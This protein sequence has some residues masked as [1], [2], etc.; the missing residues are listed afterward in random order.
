MHSSIAPVGEFGEIL[1]H[2]YESRPH[3]SYAAAYEN[4][5]I[6]SLREW[7]IKDVNNAFWHIPNLY[8]YEL[9]KPDILY[10]LLLGMLEYLI[11]WVMGFL[12]CV[13]RTTD[14]DYIW[15]RFPPY[16]GFTRPNKAYRSFSHWKGKE[17]TN[18]LRMIVAV[19]KAALDRTSGVGPITT[20]HKVHIPKAILCVRYLTDLIALAQYRVHTLGSIKAMQDYLSHV[21]N[22]KDV[23]L[24]LRATKAAKNAIREPSKDMRSE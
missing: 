10:T 9:V 23:F 2:A 19:C 6:A 4:K 24:R 13:R 8:P 20:Q 12:T 15:S 17:I 5:N 11:K 16:P 1:N 21:P 18:L 3:P 7:G 14:F 22:H